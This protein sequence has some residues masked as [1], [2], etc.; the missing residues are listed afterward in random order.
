MERLRRSR[1]LGL[2]ILHTIALRK[3]S[4][5]LVF[6]RSRHRETL[7]ENQRHQKVEDFLFLPLVRGSECNCTSV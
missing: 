7:T 4:N 3:F 6:Y 1:L 2:C 5:R